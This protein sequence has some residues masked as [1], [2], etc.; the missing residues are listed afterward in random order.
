MDS[1]TLDKKGGRRKNTARPIS[2]SGF[3]VKGEARHKALHTLKP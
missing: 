2:S 3:S 1:N